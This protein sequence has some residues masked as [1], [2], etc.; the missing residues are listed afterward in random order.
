MSKTSFA[1]A[2]VLGLVALTS[3]ISA[4]NAGGMHMHSQSGMHMPKIMSMHDH[5]S[6]HFFRH[7]PRLGFIIANTGVGCEYLYDRWLYTGDYYWKRKYY[8]CRN[9][10]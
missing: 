3:G 9:V 8:L 5:M 7:R 4:A 6:D 1:V 2:A 10:W